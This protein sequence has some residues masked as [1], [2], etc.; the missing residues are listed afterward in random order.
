MST[1]GPSPFVLQAGAD[2]KDSVPDA[3]N[4][5][6]NVLEFGHGQPQLGPSRYVPAP[7]PAPRASYGGAQ[8]WAAQPSPDPWPAPWPETS[9]ATSAAPWPEDE[10]AATWTEAPAPFPGTAEPYDRNHLDEP[11]EPLSERLDRLGAP[12]GLE[13][14]HSD[15]LDRYAEA[16][17]EQTEDA[18]TD[19]YA[20]RIAGARSWASMENSLDTL[21]SDYEKRHHQ[22]NIYVAGGIGG[23]VVLTLI[24][25]SAFLMLAS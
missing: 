12:S 20:S 6:H 9:P 3:R 17:A 23:A 5:P 22:A 25:L 2:R 1:R 8:A 4:A 18:E 19:W 13:L 14:I 11:L 10:Y 15:M 24:A 16:E 7:S 21:I